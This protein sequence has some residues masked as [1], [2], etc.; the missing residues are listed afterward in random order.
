MTCRSGKCLHHSQT[1]L[2]FDWIVKIVIDMT[3]TNRQMDRKFLACNISRSSFSESPNRTNS[4]DH[5]NIR[6]YENT[7]L[8]YV[9]SFQYL[10][11]AIVFSKGKPF[12][13]PSYK[14]WPLMLSCLGLYCFLF[15]IMLYPISAIDNFLEIV[16]VPHDWRVTLVIIIA[17]N[18]VAS[19]MLEILIVDIILWRFVFREGQGANGPRES[20]SGD[21]PQAAN[22]SWGALFL[23]RLF[24]R[25]N[26]PPKV[27]YRQLALELQECADWPPKPSIVTYASDPQSH[28]SATL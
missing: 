16:C 18:A 4:H 7:S 19:F 10:A 3:L 21:T 27:L 26:K 9:S 13:Q 20:S 8:F 11:V 22:D 23:S 12:R 1:H 28:I 14:N 2:F 25:R 17:A 15:F 24:C 5:K 6:N